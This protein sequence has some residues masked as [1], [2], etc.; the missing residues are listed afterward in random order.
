[1]KSAPRVRLS[2]AFLA[3]VALAAVLV[4]LSPSA[5]AAGAPLAGV[6][7]ELAAIL[8]G[9]HPPPTGTGPF[10]YTLA[11]ISTLVVIGPG[12]TNAVAVGTVSITNLQTTGVLAN[13][14]AISL[15]DG[16]CTP[17]REVTWASIDSADYSTDTP[18]H[19]PAWGTV[20][21][22]FPTPLVFGVVNPSISNLSCILVFARPDLASSSVSLLVQVVGKFQ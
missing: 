17:G 3:A 7:A 13:V 21:V 11:T 2:T 12:T 20:T 9:P 15:K 19:A 8:P 14:M 22:T 6:P 1:M 5:V 10:S 18:V 16:N 4:P